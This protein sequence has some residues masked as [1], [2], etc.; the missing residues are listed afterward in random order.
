MES[1]NLHVTQLATRLVSFHI[2]ST[3]II[4]SCTDSYCRIGGIL[5]ACLMEQL[6]YVKPHEVVLNHQQPRK[7]R[8]P[9]RWAVRAVPPPQM[10]AS[11]LS[12]TTLTS[13]Y[14]YHCRR[15]MWSLKKQASHSMPMPMRCRCDADGHSEVLSQ[16]C[17]FSC[18]VGRRSYTT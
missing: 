13:S 1:V 4:P 2:I 10:T 12:V 6:L 7:C 9:L 17:T 8:L 15:E 14:K 18:Y 16:K 3:T 5:V 11:D